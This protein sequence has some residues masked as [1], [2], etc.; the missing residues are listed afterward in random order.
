MRDQ[1]CSQAVSARVWFSRTPNRA[2]GAALLS[3]TTPSIESISS[4]EAAVDRVIAL[5]TTWL[6]WDGR[7]S[8]SEGNAW[9]P[10]KAM[11]RTADHLLDHLAQIDAMASGGGEIPDEWLG[12]TVTLDSDFARFTES[13]LNE[14]RQRLMRLRALVT[15]RLA[16]VAP[17]DWRRAGQGWSYGEI[18]DHLAN[19]DGYANQVRVIPPTADNQT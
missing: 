9:T 2:E 15:R 13:D 12:R 14:A 6:A 11:R 5:A 10:H 18:A 19:I 1:I 17:S 4:I 8:L 3:N 7:P 16:S